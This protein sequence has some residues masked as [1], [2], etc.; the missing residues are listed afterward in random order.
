MIAEG[1][2]IKLN[3]PYGEITSALGGP[4]KVLNGA[5]GRVTAMN[6]REGTVV[7]FEGDDRPWRVPIHWLTEWPSERSET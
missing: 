6:E 2:R 4:G 7:H 1:S 5:V 3:S